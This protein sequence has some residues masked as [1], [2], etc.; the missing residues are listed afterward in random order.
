MDDFA[1]AFELAVL[2]SVDFED[3]KFP[4]AIEVTTTFLWLESFQVFIGS[5]DF[6]C[7]RNLQI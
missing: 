4:L 6:W 1:A 2:S 5:D 3:L 7:Y